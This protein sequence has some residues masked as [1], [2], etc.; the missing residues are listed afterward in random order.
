VRHGPVSQKDSCVS[1]TEPKEP[2]KPLSYRDAGVDIDAGD[3]VVAGIRAAATRTHSARVL[4]GLGHF[5]GFYRIGPAGP[6]ATLVASADGVGTKL[7]VAIAAGQHAGVGFDIVH[8]CVNDILA[9]GATPLFFLDYFGT[10]RLRPEIA[11][12]VVTG[13]AQACAALGIALLGGET[14]EMPGLYSG[15][16]YDLVGFVIGQVEQSELIDGSTIRADDVLLGLPSSGFHTNGYSLVRAALGL[17]GVSDDAARQR[18]AQPAPFDVNVGID[19]QPQPH[20][21]LAEALL[22]PHRCY[23]D[24][25]MTLTHARIA[26]GMAHIT[27]GGLPGNI[28][29]IIP[30]GL[31]AEIDASAWQT[32]ELFR[33]VAESG[34]IA[35]DECFRAFNMGIGYV[36]VVR[37]N[38]VETAR[39]LVPELR[40]IG[41]VRPAAGD[42]R[43]VVTEPHASF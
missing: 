14:A 12:T 5:G 38:A 25:V 39:Q 6:G 26:Q 7:M 28:A 16:D 19:T 37:P 17:N 10:G 32:P 42:A 13:I 33:F 43:A 9:C 2:A 23:R 1:E 36:V 40:R 35:T 31:T 29:R 34:R 4:G 24:E 11:T 27:G 41:R 30:D 3:A 18:L 8:H 20:R 21:T 15:N 22:V